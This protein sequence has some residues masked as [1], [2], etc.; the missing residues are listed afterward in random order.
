MKI[1]KLNDYARLECFVDDVCPAQSPAPA[2]LILPGGGYRCV[3]YDTEGAPMVERFS[4]LGL[5]CFVLH[6]RV[7]EQ[8]TYPDALRDGVQAIQIIRRNA[9]EWGVRSDNLAVVGFSAGGHLAAALG[10]LCTKL[11]R[12]FLTDDAITPYVPDAMLL[13]FPVLSGTEIGHVGSMMTFFH[14]K[15]NELTQEHRDLFSLEKQITDKTPP[16]FL[17]ATVEDAVV[18]YQNSIVFQSAMVKAKRTVEMHIYPA[19]CHGMQFGYGRNDIARWP[20]QAVTFLKDSCGFK[21]PTN[22]PQ[23]RIVLSFDDAVVNHNTFVAPILKKYGFGATFFISGFDKKW[24]TEHNPA[25]LMTPDQIR[26]LH[27]QGFEIGNHTATHCMGSLGECEKELDSMTDYLTKVCGVPSPI[28]FAYPGGPYSEEMATIL[29]RRG[30]KYAR[31]CEERF[32]NPKADDPLKIPAF[33]ICDQNYFVYFSKI[34]NRLPTLDFNEN[35]PVLVFHGV[36]DV[37]HPWVN[38][39]PYHFEHLIAFLAGNGYQGIAF[40]DL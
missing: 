30:Y 26:S 13:S 25:N 35:V 3:C 20:E 34:N 14:V 18:P 19:G 17:W 38:I 22:E 15:Q 28:S 39:T 29:K 31:T 33:S 24:Y 21:F 4:K 6:Y 11:P 37:E 36:P 1:I 10:T 27:E 7:G 12:E 5:R 8:Q 23:K 2:L 9:K 32:Y 16:A 40:K